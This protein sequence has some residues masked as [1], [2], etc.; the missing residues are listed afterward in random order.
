MRRETKVALA[1]NKFLR[2]R[3]KLCDLLTTRL[4]LPVKMSEDS[5]DASVT[6]A[7]RILAKIKQLPSEIDNRWFH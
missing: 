7:E 6:L 4:G 2:D 3:K 5:F 1:R